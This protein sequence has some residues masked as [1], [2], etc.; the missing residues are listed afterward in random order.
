MLIS[1]WFP[2]IME[3]RIWY[4]TEPS[5]H[6]KCQWT[7]RWV[8]YQ[9]LSNYLQVALSL[10][11]FKSNNRFIFKSTHVDTLHFSTHLHSPFEVLYTSPPYLLA[12]FHIIHLN[13][14]AQKRFCGYVAVITQYKEELKPT[15][16]ECFD[17]VW[18]RKNQMTVTIFIL[19]TP[20]Y[21]YR[22]LKC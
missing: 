10:F 22:D 8:P 21:D 17:S 1:K 16:S 3:L 4:S 11:L 7:C 19:G 18:Q 6:L 9:N 12:V 5:G 14:V 2:G 15:W 20:D 13:H